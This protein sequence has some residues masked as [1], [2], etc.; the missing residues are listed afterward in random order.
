M[1]DLQAFLNEFLVEFYLT[2]AT[3]RE[4]GA[5]RRSEIVWIAIRDAVFSEGEARRA[6][7]RRPGVRRPAA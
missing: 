3:A 7:R 6:R 2:D 4:P 5:R 1:P